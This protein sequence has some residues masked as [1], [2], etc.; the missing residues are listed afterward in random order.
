MLLYH[1]SDNIC[2]REKKFIP[3]IPKE[4]I[5]NEDNSTQRI[6]FSDSVRGALC[7]CPRKSNYVT[8]DGC[9][10][11]ILAVYEANVNEYIPPAEL[12]GKVPDA[13]QTKEH[14]VTKSLDMKPY[15]IRIKKFSLTRYCKEMKRF[16]GDITEL[17]YENE[18]E[19]YS[20]E[21]EF[22]II[23]K[24]KYTEFEELCDRNNIL[25]VKMDKYIENTCPLK[26]DEDGHYYEY[27]YEKQRKITS[28]KVR[29]NVPPLVNTKYIWEFENKTRTKQNKKYNILSQIKL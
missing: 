9:N 6:C 24:R 21:Y 7:A 28:Y 19:S 26:L 17:I 2:L 11:I 22:K 1:I 4:R 23:S 15:L 29:Y 10:G 8:L 12:E 13:C 18:I 16:Q 5:Y 27:V 14:W 25:I 3:R 20:R